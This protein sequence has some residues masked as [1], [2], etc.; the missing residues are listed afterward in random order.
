MISKTADRFCDWATSALMSSGSRRR[1][2]E[3]D[4]DAVEAVA[5]VVVDAEDALEVHVGLEG[6]LDRAKL[7]AAA[8]GDRGDAGRE[9]AR[10]AREDDLHRGRRRCPRTRRPADDPPRPES[11]ATGLLGAE[12]VEV[13]DHGA[14]VGAIDP[15]AAGAPLEL[16]GL[17]RMLER[18]ARAEQR[19]DVDAVVDLR[20][21]RTCRLGHSLSPGC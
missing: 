1:D 8:L 15:L 3:V 16:R 18:L 5:H 12:P 10:E 14:A 9:A 4:A 20:G 19:L 6:G 13:A 21:V 11:L 17:G 7:D 2:V